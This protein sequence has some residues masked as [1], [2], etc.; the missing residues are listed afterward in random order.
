MVDVP[1]F[2]PPGLPEEDEEDEEDDEVGGETVGALNLFKH[3]PGVRVIVTGIPDGRRRP[4]EQ[5]LILEIQIHKSQMK[6]SENKVE[7]TK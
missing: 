6:S 4:R 5:K 2:A 3:I 7:N 1:L